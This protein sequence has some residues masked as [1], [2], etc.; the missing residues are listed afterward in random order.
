MARTRLR[1]GVVEI[2]IQCGETLN[3]CGPQVRAIICQSAALYAALPLVSYSIARVGETDVWNV[4]ALAV[5][6]RSYSSTVSIVASIPYYTLT[7]LPQAT[8]SELSSFL[9]LVQTFSP[10]LKTYAVSTVAIVWTP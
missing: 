8:E 5:D 3:L 4:T 7:S 10:V 6:A 1:D 2:D 9:T